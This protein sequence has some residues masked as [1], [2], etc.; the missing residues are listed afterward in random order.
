MAPQDSGSPSTLPDTLDLKGV[1]GRPGATTLDGF[2]C[3]RGPPGPRGPPGSPGSPGPAGIA[4]G[5]PDLLRS[6]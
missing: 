5:T 6:F 3:A 2:H 4:A 1:P